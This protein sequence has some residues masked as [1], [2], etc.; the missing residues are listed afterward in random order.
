MKPKYHPTV[1]A[2]KLAPGLPLLNCYTKEGWREKLRFDF[3]KEVPKSMT[4]LA[5]F[6]LWRELRGLDD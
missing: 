4:K 2:R 6:R 1:I 3:C 5:M